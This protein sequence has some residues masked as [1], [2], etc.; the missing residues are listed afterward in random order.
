[1][2]RQQDFAFDEYCFLHFELR[3]TQYRGGTDLPFPRAIPFHRDE[4]GK[5][6]SVTG[7]GD[8]VS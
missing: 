1:M 6:E 7:P 4:H 3:A 2:Y 8:E 5:G